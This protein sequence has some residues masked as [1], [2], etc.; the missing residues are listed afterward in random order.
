MSDSISLYSENESQNQ[1]VA[2]SV[3]K[4]TNFIPRAPFLL[5][6]T[7]K[8]ILILVLGEKYRQTNVVFSFSMD[9]I[10]AG[11]WLRPAISG[12]GSSFIGFIMEIMQVLR[13]ILGS[14]SP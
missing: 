12:R 7:K 13:S 5:F 6:E 11:F 8:Q 9:C 4:P 1:Y 10:L 14:I 2:L 3:L